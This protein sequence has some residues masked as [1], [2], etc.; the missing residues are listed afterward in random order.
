MNHMTKIPSTTPITRSRAGDI[1]E[2]ALKP[3]NAVKKK[4]NP[5]CTPT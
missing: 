4:P 2:V 5:I 1:F 3:G